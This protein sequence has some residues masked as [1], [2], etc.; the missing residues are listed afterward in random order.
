MSDRPGQD[1]PGHPVATIAAL[2]D[3]TERRVQQLS[4][5]GVIPRNSHGRYEVGL[6]VR[7]Y[8]RYL[9]ERAMK[10]DPAGADDAGASRAKLLQARARYATLEADQFEATL[11]KRVDVEKAWTAIISNIRTRLLAIP[12]ATATAILYLQTA[13]QISG[14]LTTAVTEALDDIASTPVYL[15]ANPSAGAEPGADGARGAAD[16]QAATEADGFAMGGPASDAQLGVVR[17]AGALEHQPPAVPAGDD[18][19]DGRSG[20]PAGGPAD[21]LA[22][23]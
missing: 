13:G 15:D 21:V 2:L 1:R 14:L 8:V 10:G 20:D 22:N 7:G 3:L 18:G 6:A 11:L 5:E 16:S 19:R 17:G 12:Q 23:R 9:R 4:A